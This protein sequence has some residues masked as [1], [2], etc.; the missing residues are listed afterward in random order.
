MMEVTTLGARAPQPTTVRIIGSLG[1]L[2]VWLCDSILR[3]SLSLHFA[4][5]RSALLCRSRSRPR[6]M[7]RARHMGLILGMF[8]W[9][10]KF[11]IIPRAQRNSATLARGG[12]PGLQLR[13]RPG[14]RMERD[15]SGGQRGRCSTRRGRYRET[16]SYCNG[17]SSP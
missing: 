1:W 3:R 2:W 10:N 17:R 14:V 6:V 11:L 9:E 5:A 7:S 16:C 13:R 8:E 12:N 4:S 15:D